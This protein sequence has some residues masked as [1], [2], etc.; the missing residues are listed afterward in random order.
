MSHHHHHHEDSSD[1]NIAVAFF[2]NLFFTVLELFGGFFTNSVAI[3]SDA[4]HD[5]GDTLSLG[6]AWY[7]QRL[8]KKEK[9]RLFSD[10]NYEPK[11]W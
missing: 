5:F 2:L 6:L 4:V 10:L 11:E 7:F 9:T 1:T 3:I 8:S